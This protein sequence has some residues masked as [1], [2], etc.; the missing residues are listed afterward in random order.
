MKLFK[1]ENY[2]LTVSEEALLITP[3]KKIW[4]RD[5][6]SSKEKA[7]SEL[8]FLYFYCDPRSDYAFLVDDSIREEKIKEQIGFSKNWKPDKLIKEA[9]ET[10]KFLTQSSASLLLDSTR[11]AIEVIREKLANIDFEEEDSKGRRVNTLANVTST[12]KSVPALIKE[13]VE[14]ER[15]VNQEIN[16]NSRLRGQ[17]VKKLLEDGV[18]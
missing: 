15:A 12:L 13:V 14:T 7:L 10:Y 1:F 4:N 8:G 3:F 18:V 9:I 16:E 11:K 6:S 17:G 2:K 5:R